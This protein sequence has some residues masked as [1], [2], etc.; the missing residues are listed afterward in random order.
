MA[1]RLYPLVA[2]RA[3]RRCEYCLAPES[4][5][6]SPFEVEHITPLALGGAD[7]EW[8]LALSCRSC[9]ASKFQATAAP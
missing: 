6:N 1:H 4:I 3:Q 7:E 2:E 9:N 8:N 5:F